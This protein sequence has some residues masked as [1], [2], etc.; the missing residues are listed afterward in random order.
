MQPEEN[1][2]DPLDALINA[3]VGTAIAS[4]YAPAVAAELDHMQ[5]QQNVPQDPAPSV[6]EHNMA[7]APTAAP[8][9]Q[10]S[11]AAASE[12]TLIERS[13]IPTGRCEETCTQT[14]WCK[15]VSTLRHLTMSRIQLI[16]GKC[17]AGKRS[18]RA[19][20]KRSPVQVSLTSTVT[21]H[22]MP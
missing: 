22:L 15:H 16:F 8:T 5:P 2:D 20:N 9:P 18:C 4:G 3:P 11:A 6:C 12:Q 17:P 1:H 13:H 7:A 10:P 21:Q 14:A 19:K